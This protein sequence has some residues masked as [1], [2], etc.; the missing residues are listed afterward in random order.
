MNIINIK[1]IIDIKN[2]K[3]IKNIRNIRNNS[4]HLFILMPCHYEQVLLIYHHLTIVPP[5]LGPGL[6]EGHLQDSEQH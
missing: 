4:L 3:N 2:I 1:N 6:G 5:T